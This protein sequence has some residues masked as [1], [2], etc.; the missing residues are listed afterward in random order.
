MTLYQWLRSLKIINGLTKL[1][2]TEPFIMDPK[3]GDIKFCAVTE[4][5]ILEMVPNNNNQ[6]NSKLR[7]YFIIDC[8]STDLA[9]WRF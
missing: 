8:P 1:N 9:S 3:Q 7:L 5:L 2:H 4:A 6:T